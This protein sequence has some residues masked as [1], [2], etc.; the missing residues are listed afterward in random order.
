MQVLCKCLLSATQHHIKNNDVFIAGIHLI[1]RT[2]VVGRD[3][4]IEG[5]V[6]DTE[7]AIEASRI[8]LT[9]DQA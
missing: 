6:G 5:D 7:D 9:R 3:H 8:I 1:I 2:K 4:V